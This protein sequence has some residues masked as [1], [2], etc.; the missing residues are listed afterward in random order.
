MQQ[1][2]ICRC[3]L[4]RAEF[5]NEIGGNALTV[6]VLAHK[7]K[8]ISKDKRGLVCFGRARE[9]PFQALYLQV[10]IR[11]IREEPTYYWRPFSPLKKRSTVD[12]PIS[13]PAWKISAATSAISS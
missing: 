11:E 10:W 13:Q 8:L 12:D 2:T 4:K 7:R 6:S 1:H 3:Q 5:I 9:Y